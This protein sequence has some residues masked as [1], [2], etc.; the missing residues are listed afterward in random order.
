MQQDVCKVAWLQRYS[1]LVALITREIMDE[2]IDPGH[3]MSPGG[4]CEKN[5]VGV[6]GPLPKNVTLFMTKICEFQ[7]PI[8]DLTL[9][10]YPV[11]D[12]PYT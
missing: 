12:L 4:Y 8:Y 9:H 3:E 11:S 2:I 10:Q 1:T 5:W 6:C 7:C